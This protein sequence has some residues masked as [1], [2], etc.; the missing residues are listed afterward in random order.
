MTALVSFIEPDVGSWRARISTLTADRAK[1]LAV[2]AHHA[3]LFAHAY[4]FHLNFRFG[5]MTPMDLLEF[6]AVHDLKGIKI[7]VEDGEENS[8]LASPALRPA[9]RA[10]A[11]EMGL[12][13]HIETSSTTQEALG[14]AI[15]IAKETGATSVR[16]YP[17]Y[18]ARVSEI[19]T[20]TI[21]DLKRLKELDAGR[22][23]RVTLEQHEDLTSSELV[24]IVES[25]RDPK[26]SLLFDFGNMVNAYERP[27]EALRVQSAHVTEVHIKD[28][29]VEPDR[30]GHAQ[31]GCVSGTGDVPFADLLLHLLL[32]GEDKPQVTAFALEEEADYF[33]PAM[34]FPNEKNDPLILFRSASLTDPGKTRIAARLKRE[35]NEATAQISTVRTLL[36]KIEQAALDVAKK[37]SGDKL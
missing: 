25:V 36:R 32:L 11:K 18:E 7:H 17:R 1:E 31:R 37:K 10:R 35:A 6:A 12:D 5:R 21:E 3:P 8:L 28:C 20:K 26:L 27:L 23:L 14:E 4:S 15:T 13:V 30:G 24:H 19:I 9:F 34:R 22:S 2:R 33:A 29:R 16:C